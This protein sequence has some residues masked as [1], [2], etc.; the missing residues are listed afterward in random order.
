MKAA[1]ECREEEVV[2]L[3]LQHQEAF[4]ICSF[5]FLQSEL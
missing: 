4:S 2:G 1:E 5:I 3:G